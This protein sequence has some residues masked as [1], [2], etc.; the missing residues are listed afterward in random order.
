M[1]SI[2]INE[3]TN[4]SSKAEMTAGASGF[5]N[6]VGDAATP[7]LELKEICKRYGQIDVLTNVSFT[8]NKAE[9]IGLL[10]D[11]GAGK[12]TLVKTISGVVQPDQGELVW[13]GKPVQFNSRE[14]SANYGVE[15]I[16]QDSALV[17]SMS[18]ARNIFM[19]REIRNR[20]GFM[21]LRQMREIAAE[22]LK[23]I[24][25]IEGID[26]P[27]KLVGSLSGGQKQAVAIARAVHF[28]RSLLVLDEPTSALAVRAT[29]ALFDYLRHLRDQ[30]LSSI[31]V[32][33]DLY[34]AYRICDRFVVMSRG[35]TI[36]KAA[37][38]ETSIEEL[39]EKVSRG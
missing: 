33:H 19:G 36:L 4:V 31:L 26:S 35:R 6:T 2:E 5:A 17:D 13:D 30:G 37:K 18:I 22:V 14:V 23:T 39:T 9:V 16:F 10:G 27:D 12:S 29:E 3:V 1:T 15:T 8:V 21:D 34:D 32:T 11:N 28:K 25:A 7:L 20:F 24:V 38:S